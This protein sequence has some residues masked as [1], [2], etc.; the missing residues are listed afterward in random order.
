MAQLATTPYVQFH[1]PDSK[2]YHELLTRATL[3]F[4]PAK[5]FDLIPD[6]S[7]D[8][9]KVLEEYRKMFGYDLLIK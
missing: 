4:K 2:E 3:L 5:E 9:A 6:N 7:G 1:K 8:I